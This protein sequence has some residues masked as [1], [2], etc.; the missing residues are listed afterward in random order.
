MS[1][2]TGAGLT[3]A[4]R[5]LVRGVVDMAGLA[6]FLIGFLITHDLVKATWGLVVGSA[7]GLAIGWIAERRIAPLPLVAGAAAVVFGTLTLVF[8]DVRFVK[9][10][11]TFLNIAFATF[12][13]GGSLLRRNPLKLLIGDKIELPDEAWR[14]LTLHYGLYFV[15]AA[16][17]NEFVWRTQPDRIWVLFRFP[18]LIILAFVFSLTQMPL[19]MKH[20]RVDD[21]RG[22]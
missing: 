9:M 21:R 16:I 22:D 10:K 19:L 3:P 6:V 7:L 11:P 1:H 8:H 12:L 5:G 18:G 17:L 14:K 13:L 4:Q 2:P 15:F 20:G